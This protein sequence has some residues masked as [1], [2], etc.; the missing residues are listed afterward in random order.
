MGNA[1]NLFVFQRD[2]DKARQRLVK[3]DQPASN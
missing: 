3:G 1:D 2:V